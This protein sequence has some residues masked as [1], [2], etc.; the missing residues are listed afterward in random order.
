LTP[1]PTSRRRFLQRGASVLAAASLGAGCHSSV[2]PGRRG[3]PDRPNVVLVVIDT[4]RTDH[5]FGDRARTPNID[6]LA[7][8]GIS[9]TQVYPSAMPTVPARNS[10]LSGRR[11]FPFRGWQDVYAGLPPFPGWAPIH[12]L[13]NTFT[14]VLRRAGYWTAYV[15]DNPF[16][17]FA[18]PYERLRRS[19]DRFRRR[20]GQVGGRSTGVT[21]Q[22]LRRWLPDF[23]AR[24]PAMRSRVRRYLANGGYSRDEARSFSARVFRDGARL[25][26]HGARQRPFA[27]VVDTF[28]PHEP[29][30]P[31]RPYVD[32]Y[33]DPDYHGPEPARQLNLPVES[34]LAEGE[35]ELMLSRMRAL[36][37]AE[38]TLTDRWLGVFLDRLHDLRLERETVLMLA[39]DHGFYLG[40]HGLTGKIHDVL[41]PEL[42]HVPLILVD[43]ERRKAGHRS[44]YRASTH[45]VAPTLLSMTGV[46]RPRA[47]E[48]A[49]L[50]P[51]LGRGAPP[52]RRHSFG[53]YSNS[54]YVRTDDWAMFAN[55][56]PSG[57]SLY[58]LGADPG[59]RRGVAAVHPRQAKQLYAFV[60]EQ[61]GGRLP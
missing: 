44:D 3:R 4:L 14:S 27:L 10:I 15:T 34:Y 36:Y 18:P 23:L 43:P 32:M 45:D 13:R 12:D 60:R 1:A 48:G 29:W 53:G 59:E 20:G 2:G 57:F 55:N 28:E 33:G 26:E 42:I 19:F 37:A 61:V 22:E 30:T 50:S 51:L 40:E 54:F 7:R 11:T 21:D 49:D 25:L 24:D 58:D 39:S 16:L 52:R 8:E 38:V 5:A 35:R 47:M 6:A 31:P 41:H 17:G 56:R 9:F 46:E